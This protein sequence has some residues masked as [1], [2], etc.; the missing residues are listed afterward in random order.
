V[1]PSRGPGRALLAAAALLSSGCITVGARTE[2][3]VVREP[4][5]AAEASAR[6]PEVT[7]VLTP[8]PAPIEDPILDSPWRNEPAVAER[9]G[10]WIEHWQ[11]NGKPDFQIYL[12]RMQWFRPLVEPELERRELPRSLLYL[13]MVES[14][15]AAAAISHASAVGLWQFMAP[16]A[17]ARGLTIT[18]LVDERRD[19]VRAT[20]EALGF[21]EELHGRFGSWYLAL[22]AYNGGPSRMTR[23]LRERAPLAPRSDS[24]F[25]A[26]GPELPRETREFVPRLIA[27]AT[28]ASDPVRWGY[29]PPS[30]PGL[31]YDEVTVDGAV[32]LDVVA[33]A[34]GVPQA[35]VERLN[36]HLL[37]GFTPPQGRS[38][39]RIPAG[40]GPEFEDALARIPPSERVSFLEH[41]V[42]RGETFS[43]IARRYGVGVSTLQAANAETPPNRLQ[44]GQW[45]VV[46]VSPR[47]RAS[48]S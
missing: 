36:P 22:A 45:I 32:S 41:R 11:G 3:P 4:A 2:R 26:L 8:P 6:A 29:E 7:P 35:E 15:Y 48:G 39:L 23:I 19:P 42:R 18:A 24:L 27:A 20:P 37:R 31:A 17:R 38:I 9:V 46:P 25:V 14:G 28:L 47:A 16:T 30:G 10:F 40:R 1:T 5:L 13:P 12:E 21:L 34:A 33:R 44:I 43:H